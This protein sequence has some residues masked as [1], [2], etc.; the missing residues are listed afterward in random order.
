MP[1]VNLQAGLRNKKENGQGSDRCHFSLDRG[2]AGADV[3]LTKPFDP[4][5]L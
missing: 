5:I 1:I 2:E 3:Y 4:K